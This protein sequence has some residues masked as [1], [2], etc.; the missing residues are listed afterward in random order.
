MPG[1][2]CAPAA[3]RYLLPY[4]FFPFFE[5]VPNSKCFVRLMGFIRFALHFV[6]SNLST[7]F[8]VV[9]AF[10]W[11]TGFVWPPKPICLLSYR[12][13][14]WAKLLA[15]PALYCVTL[16]TWCLRHFLFFPC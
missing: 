3:H 7:I 12:R 4:S 10:L 2:W 1:H 16:W 8:F 9:F 6:H 11:K 15:L 13:L 14:P 5:S